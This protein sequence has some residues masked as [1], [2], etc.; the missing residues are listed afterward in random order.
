MGEDRTLVK[1]GQGILDIAHLLQSTEEEYYPLDDESV[2]E[3][4]LCYQATRD[5]DLWRMAEYLAMGRD[6]VFVD[7]GCGKGRVVCFAALQGIKKVIGVELRKELAEFVQWYV[8]TRTL[9]VPVE[10]Y[11][12]DAATFMSDEATIFYLFNP[13][14]QKTVR[15]VVNNISESLAVH[16]RGIRIVYNNCVY[17]RC[18]DNT[19]WLVREGQIPG[20]PIYVWKN[21]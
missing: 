4:A 3:D 1:P 14:G 2:Y 20:T 6:D 9:P 19:G 8:R 21:R 15:E 11:N 13:F 16:P 12:G 18:L 7:F 17:A 10:I 5:R